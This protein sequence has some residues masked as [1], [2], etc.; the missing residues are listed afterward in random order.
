VSAGHATRCS[1]FG[2]LSSPSSPPS[3]NG[4]GLLAW[5]SIKVAVLGFL[6]LHDDELPMADCH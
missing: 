2:F 6:S 5:I 3:A 4:M 1:M